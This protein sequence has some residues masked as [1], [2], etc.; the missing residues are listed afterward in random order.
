MALCV[1]LGV[2]GGLWLDRRFDSLPLFTLLGVALGSVLAFYGVYRM[3]L[4][5]L[6]Q[7]Q[8]PKKG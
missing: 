4:P 6:G 2:A 1:I 5:L 8:H 7:G 3:V